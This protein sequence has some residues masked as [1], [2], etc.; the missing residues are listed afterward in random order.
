MATYYVLGIEI[1]KMAEVRG[2]H[3]DR[4]TAEG[5][6]AALE[7]RKHKLHCQRFAVKTATEVKREKLILY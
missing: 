7:K 5:Q 1:F 4:K 2:I 3:P 6:A